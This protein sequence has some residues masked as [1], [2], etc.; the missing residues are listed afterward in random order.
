LPIVFK[1]PD[2]SD[3]FAKMSVVRADSPPGTIPSIIK[4]Y[5]A[6][7]VLYFPNLRFDIDHDFWAA[8]PCDSFR[9][10]KKL[11]SCPAADDYA[12]DPLLDR[13]L[14]QAQAPQALVRRLKKEIRRFYAEA[15]PVYEALFA[16]YGFTRRQVVWRLN[17]IRNENLHVDTYV[18]DLPDHFARL[19]I[20]LDNQPRI[21]M[22]SYAIDEMF[23]RFGSQIPLEIL[24]SGTPG[25]IRNAV[26]EAAFGGKSTIWWDG[27]PRHVAYFD[28][29]EVWAV[30]SRQV[31]HQI[32]YGR[33]AVSID[34]FVDPASMNKP[35]RHYLK[36]A[37]AFRRRALA[38]L[39]ARAAAE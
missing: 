7:R 12:K 27:Q 3:P 32:F 9:R 18:D 19:F 35:K 21:W 13:R 31:A 2:L 20:N 23:D 10:L 38:G 16:G 15:L 36:M 28:P 11:S 26:N 1:H 14:E 34:F 37:N 39:E 5:E 25:Q 29:G 33:R 30:D 4:P 17:T 6:G 24:R 8:L 22:I